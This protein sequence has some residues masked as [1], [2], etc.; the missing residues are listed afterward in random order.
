VDTAKQAVVHNGIFHVYGG[1]RV[2]VS[3]EEGPA[4]LEDGKWHKVKLVY[5]GSSG[6]VDVWVDGITSPAMRAV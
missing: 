3:S 4:T 1:D 6:R 5:D 2:R